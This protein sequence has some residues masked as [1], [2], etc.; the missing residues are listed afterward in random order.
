VFL[1][2]KVTTSKNI[3]GTTSTQVRRNFY[4]ENFCQFPGLGKKRIDSS[5]YIFRLFG[6]RWYYILRLKKV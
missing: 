2:V 4:D 3:P 5:W 6:I 1:K